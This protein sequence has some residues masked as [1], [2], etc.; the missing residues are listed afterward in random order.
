[1]PHQAIHALS[2]RRFISKFSVRAR[3]VAITLIPVVGFLANGLTFVGG[4]RE[5]GAALDSLRQATAGA[6]ASREFKGAVVTIQAAARGFA[7]HPRPSH[8]QILSSAQDAATAQFARIRQFSVGQDRGNIDAIER[9][10]ARMR[11]NFQE[12]NKEYERLGIDVDSG[13]RA[14]LR[15]AAGDVERVISLDMSWLPE[16][17]S[18]QLIVSLLAMRR[19]EA[20]YMLDR[21]F[22]DRT[23]FN[24]EVGT[25]IKIIQGVVAA[26]ILK[27]QILQTVRNYADAFE[28]WIAANTEITSRVAGIDSDAEFL[29]RSAEANVSRSNEQRAQAS[30][31]LNLS[32][33]H[34]RNAIFQ[35]GLATVI[36]GLMFGLWIGQTITR[37]LRGLAG[38]MKRLADGDTSAPIPATRAK[39]E[40]GAMARAVVVFR[41][42]MIERERL[43]ATQI[44]TARERERRGEAIA[45]TITRFETSV[46]DALSKV[47]EAAFRLE[48]ASGHL[49]GAADRVSAETQTA[50]QRVGFASGN[51]TTAASSVEE[52]AASI[53]GIAQ[54]A[55]RSTEVARR[56]VDEARRTVGTMAELG[57][58]AT[59][60]GEVVGLIQAIARQTN[61][62]AL[63]A[64]I[65]AA[66]AGAAGR[67]F[68]VVAA[69]VKSLAGQ[70]SKATE[71]IA[72]QVGAI[73]SAVADAA[74]AIEQVNAIIEEMSAIASTVAV[75]VEEQ[76][77][78]VS[79]IAE[80]VSCASSEAR[81]GA[82]AMSR[83]AGATS[84]ARATAVDV[85][86]L[87]DTLAVEAE[88]L[89]GE[90]RRF[91]ADVQAA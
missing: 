45:V 14:K 2:P 38:V 54:Q 76:N 39:D 64:T 82:E 79:N 42:N 65:E 88:S 3:I 22:S 41:D 15:D 23:A 17:V 10:F 53:A 87:A 31:A 58:A 71:E 24:A 28:A 63:N 1:M 57:D 74:H 34:T 37:P 32:Q 11:G 5:V 9:T 16:S 46:D 83:V 49:N 73:Q 50:E 61:L 29:I 48:S 72:G 52:L 68:A 33:Q 13:I 69:E 7:D 80:G 27:A 21:G 20:A 91:L 55:T 90:V 30:A 8:L 67:G 66:R 59:R 44:E 56:A 40:L 12:L 70:T 81:S 75:T 62:L 18:H 89:D 86:A 60:I 78:A 47:R 51:V 85:K 26:E 84:D 43:T 6:D 4:E 19:H 35:V 36:L 25:F 77:Q